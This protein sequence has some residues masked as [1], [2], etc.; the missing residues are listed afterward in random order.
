MDFKFLFGI[1]Y[2]SIV[3][4]IV[5][6]LL[7]AGLIIMPMFTNKKRQKQVNQ[8]YDSVR[9]GDRI[10]TVGGIIGTVVELK[11]N[12]A[13]EKEIVL[14]TGSGANKST[15]IFDMQA[16]YMNLTG[17]QRNALAEKERTEQIENKKNAEKAASETAEPEAEEKEEQAA[18]DQEKK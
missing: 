14:E 17:L 12:E 13:G 7:V 8:L 9:A 3:L 11:L 4:I 6:V 15:M 16:V 18:E 5:M 1:E 2:G 10:K